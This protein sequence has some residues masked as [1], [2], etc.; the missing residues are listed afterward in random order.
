MLSEEIV[1]NSVVSYDDMFMNFTQQFLQ[2][3]QKIANSDFKTATSFDLK[4]K[5]RSEKK[6]INPMI[7]LAKPEDIDEIIFIYKDI[8][9][10]TYPYK[11]M[12]DREE[13]RKMLHSPNVE[14]LIFETL[15]HEIV[16]CFTFML[17]FNK[18]MGN[19]RGFNLKK[20]F[21]GKL[22]IMKMAMGSI[23]AMYRKYNDR[24]FRWYGECRT[25]HS[26]SQYFL[27]A[28]GFKPVGFYPCKD[29]F[30]NKVESDLLIM[31][32]DE[33]ALTTMR[34]NKTPKILP[35]AFNGF[36]YSDRRYDLGLC[37]IEHFNSLS[38][39]THKIK[40]LQKRIYTH[41][42]KDR[43]GYETI[44][45]SFENSKSY[46]EFLYTPT[47]QNFEK[48][49]YKVKCLEELYVFVQNFINCGIKLEVRYCEVFISAY[50]PS[51]QKI[52]YDFG[53]KPR[54]YV[55]SWKYNQNINKFEDCILFNWFKGEVSNLQLLD[56]GKNLVE[57]LGIRYVYEPKIISEKST[58]S[59]IIP[60]KK[61]LSKIWNYPKI[62]KAS[63]MS[64]LVLYLFLLFGSLGVASIQG[65]HITTH[66]ISKLGS[67]EVTQ[68]PFLFDLSSLLG[69]FT[70]L[71]FNCYLS[72]RIKIPSIREKRNYQFN[73]QIPRYAMISGIIG[74]FGIMFVGLF[75]LDRAFGLYHSLFSVLAF[76]GFGFSLLLF[77]LSIVCFNTGI[78]KFIGIL[79]IAPLIISIL[80]CFIISPLLEWILLFSIL[81]SLI[82]LFGWLI[83][84]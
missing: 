9:D 70:T 74:S 71:I 25:A 69:G 57:F 16:G 75:S 24:I 36:S 37:K 12:E 52:F 31:S 64:G 22:D 72:K 73:Y 23:I 19:I 15:E 51:H 27:S 20:K 65:Y 3:F 53:L 54:G 29:V 81:G 46:F 78:P 79:G 56:E 1:P 50:K 21:L 13:I 33:R 40:L 63:I 45:F 43:F 82:P 4:I 14:W 6:R 66:T 34:S 2:S 59:K 62:L 83:F 48:T 55:P 11:E 39:D 77:G 18:R 8:Y 60:C 76:G 32:Y 42:S 68:F 28:L 41:I 47:V 67:R 80:H 26:K 49:H 35:E 38:L 44:K 84:N 58:N 61:K 7:R 5:G 17:D 30:Y 10:N